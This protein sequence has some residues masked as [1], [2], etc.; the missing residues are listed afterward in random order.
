MDSKDIYVK[1]FIDKQVGSRFQT[2]SYFIADLSIDR[3][4]TD[5]H[6]YV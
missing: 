2:F 4:A 1:G 3:V 6:Y 5:I